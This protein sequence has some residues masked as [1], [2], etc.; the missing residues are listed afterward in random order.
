MVI[1]KIIL[2]IIIIIG[3]FII[4][5]KQVEN[6]SDGNYINT[7]KYNTNFNKIY[8]HLPYDIKVKNEKL[9]IY[10]FGNDE[11][12]EKFS[13]IYDLN[14]TEKQIKLIEGINW[15]CWK[16]PDNT[17]Y[18]SSLQNYY[19]RIINEFENN[20]N[21]PIFD[22]P[23]AIINSK[24]NII[25]KSLNRYKKCLDNGNILML[26][27][28]LI[29]YRDNKPLARHIK[30]IS[31]VSPLNISFLFVKI[32]GVISQEELYK[33]KIQSATFNNNY[34]EF[35]PERTIIYDNDSFIYDLDD[36]RANSSMSFNL[37][38]KLLKDLTS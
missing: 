3:F 30:I 34:L 36:K 2:I 1:I 12:N 13:T 18:L 27:I 6:F 24:F 11:L 33:N 37:Y 4:I 14:N 31:V 26:D 17:S 19:N 21:N 28:D 20:L 15:S 35:I 16:L 25:N 29:I 23:N 7:N 22:I 8:S 10:D 38:N 32:I 5:K 9:L